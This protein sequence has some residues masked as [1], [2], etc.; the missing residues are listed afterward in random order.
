MMSNQ[1]SFDQNILIDFLKFRSEKDLSITEILEVEDF[2]TTALEEGTISHELFYKHISGRAM[3][4]E[5]FDDDEPFYKH[6]SIRAMSEE[7]FDDVG[8]SYE[9][10]EMTKEAEV[11]YKELA[12]PRG[13]IDQ[14]KKTQG[15]MIS[16]RRS[17]NITLEESIGNIEIEGISITR[18]EQG[19]NTLEEEF[20]QTKVEPR[21]P[22]QVEE[23]VR[24]RI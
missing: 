19:Q 21:P 8:D 12:I 1:I 23:L 4:E 2:S 13:K 22:E 11:P 6:I 16:K 20:D 10:L 14:V 24:Q 17:S 9:E 15:N 3:S 7:D 5:V 18:R